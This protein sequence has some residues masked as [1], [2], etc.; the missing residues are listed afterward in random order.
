MSFCIPSDVKRLLN[1]AIVLPRRYPQVRH[2][3]E[4]SE[5]PTIITP[6][7]FA[8]IYWAEVTL[9]KCFV[10]WISWNRQDFVSK[11]MEKKLCHYFHCYVL[12]TNLHV[13]FHLMFERRLQPKA[14]LS[15]STYQLHQLYRNT[16]ATA[17]SS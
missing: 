17:K 3:P 4:I 9:A 16:V 5:N 13:L 8:V 6:H 14:V 1:E 7:Q 10:A 11:G 12:F 15:S 2:L